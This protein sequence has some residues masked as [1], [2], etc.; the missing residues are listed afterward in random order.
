MISSDDHACP[1]Q[2]CPYTCPLYDIIFKCYTWWSGIVSTRRHVQTCR[3]SPSSSISSATQDVQKTLPWWI[4]PTMSVTLYC[5]LNVSVR[6]LPC[7][8]TEWSELPCKTQPL[9]MVNK[10]IC[11]VT[12]TSFGPLKKRCLQCH[13]EKNTECLLVF[14]CSKQEE[15]TT[16][17]LGTWSTFSQSLMTSVIHSEVVDNTP[18]WYLSIPDTR[19]VSPV[20]VMWCCYNSSSS[21]SSLV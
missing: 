4:T 18:V 21:S 7:F 3:L 2:A 14:T 8:G 6:K 13:I 16:K 20:I 11:P 1:W 17:R 5:L 12:I 19:S 15:V 9:E 10:N